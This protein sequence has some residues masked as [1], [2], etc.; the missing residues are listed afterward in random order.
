MQHNLLSASR[1][2]ANITFEELGILLHITAKNVNVCPVPV[3][4]VFLCAQGSLRTHAV[5][6]HWL[7]LLAASASGGDGGSRDDYRGQNGRPH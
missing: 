7:L 1:L 3:S 4:D 2:Y 6:S 5:C